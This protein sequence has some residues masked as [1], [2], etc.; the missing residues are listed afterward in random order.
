MTLR[1]RARSIVDCN[2]LRGDPSAAAARGSGCDSFWCHANRRLP[3]HDGLVCGVKSA[4]SPLLCATAQHVDVALALPWPVQECRVLYRVRVL[5]AH[6][7]SEAAATMRKYRLI[8]KKGEG[9][10]SE[11]LKAQSVKNGKCYAI[12][13]M[14]THFT[15]IEQV[16]LGGQRVWAAGLRPAFS[17]CIHAVPRAGEQLE[18]DPGVAEAVTTSQC[19]AAG[20]GAI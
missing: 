7:W 20:R 2:S 12:K 4:L 17:P 3:R 13:C 9:T 14:K 16:R 15:S 19:G 18:G 11:V 10:F 8:A 6:R 1:A 5:E